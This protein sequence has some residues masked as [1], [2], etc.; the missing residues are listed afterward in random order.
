MWS[1]TGRCAYSYDCRKFVTGCDDSCPTA[2]EHPALAPGRI[3]PAWRQRQKLIRRFP[4]LM[5]V[6]PSRWLAREAR[7]GFWKHHRVEIIP[8]GVPLNIF[9]P[10]KRALSRQMLGLTAPGLVL[11]VAAQDLREPRKGVKLLLQA[12]ALVKH[13]PL[14]ILSMGEGELSFKEDGVS[15]HPLGRVEDDRTKVL[16]YNA[17]DALAHPAP[18]DNLPNVVMEAL[19][20]GTPAI[21]FKVGGVPEMILPRKSGWLAENVGVESLAITLDLALRELKEG[22]DLRSACRRTAETEY[23]LELQANRYLALFEQQRRDAQP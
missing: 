11:L 6:T 4:D 7:N 8:N 1:F 2:N 14:T 22:M 9:H 21:G 15:Y 23:A 10:T 19:A 16:A 20:C 12:L 13:R 3:A 17:A 18:V 5:A